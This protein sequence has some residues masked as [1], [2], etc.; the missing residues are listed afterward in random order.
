M[1]ILNIIDSCKRKERTH[2]NESAGYDDQRFSIVR[3]FLGASHK[4]LL[5]IFNL[6]LKTGLYQTNSELVTLHQSSK[7]A[8]IMIGGP[9]TNKKNKNNVKIMYNYR[10]KY[11]TDK[12]IR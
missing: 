6:F 8:I 12:Y 10:Y 1:L 11:L 3:K 2:T 4:P 5:Q 9:K 7:A